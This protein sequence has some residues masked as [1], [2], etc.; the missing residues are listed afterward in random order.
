MEVPL[1]LLPVGAATARQAMLAQPAQLA[2]HPAA[3]SAVL[4]TS[5]RVEHLH[6]ESRS[7]T[8]DITF[9]SLSSIL[10]LMRAKSI[11][12]TILKSSL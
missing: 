2:S 11:N 1:P 10:P 5:F 12:N 3:L 4:Y 6:W 7:C 8:E 9:F